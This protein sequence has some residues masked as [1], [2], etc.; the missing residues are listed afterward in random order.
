MRDG[1]KPHIKTQEL[2][3]MDQECSETMMFSTDGNIGFW[4]NDKGNCS[5][6]TKVWG[7]ISDIINN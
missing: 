4:L 7:M 2:L 3:N 6:D 5:S 1:K